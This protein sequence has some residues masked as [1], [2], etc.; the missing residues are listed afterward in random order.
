MTVKSAR[1]SALCHHHL[2]MAGIPDQAIQKLLGHASVRTKSPMGRWQAAY[3]GW[4]T[5]WRLK[6]AAGPACVAK[7]A[8]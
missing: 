4:M 7:N 5:N 3:S 2:K 6:L 1:R 8:S